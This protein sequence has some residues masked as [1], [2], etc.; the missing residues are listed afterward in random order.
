MLQRCVRKG[1]ALVR[2]PSATSRSEQLIRAG[3]S[4]APRFSQVVETGGKEQLPIADDAPSQRRGGFKASQISLTMVYYLVSCS[5]IFQS[6]YPTNR[7]CS[8][9]SGSCAVYLHIAAGQDPP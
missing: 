7:L 4:T 6:L 3:C 2:R 5:P 9:P 8:P 1:F